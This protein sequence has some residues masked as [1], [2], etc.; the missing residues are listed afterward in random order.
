MTIDSAETQ[1]RVFKIVEDL[2]TDS[3]LEIHPEMD[4]FAAGVLDSFGMLGYISAL[5]EE[6]GISISNEDLIPQNLWNIVA[7]IVTVEKY[8]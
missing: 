2:K 3:G 5:E 6:F 1:A 7:T 4:L 8:M